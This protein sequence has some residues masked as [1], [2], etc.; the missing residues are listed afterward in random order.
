MRDSNAWGDFWSQENA[1]DIIDLNTERF[2]EEIENTVSQM[3]E[4]W[5]AGDAVMAGSAFAHFWDVLMTPLAEQDM[6]AE[7]YL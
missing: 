5:S 2:E 7:V 6:A 1:I 4:G 3:L